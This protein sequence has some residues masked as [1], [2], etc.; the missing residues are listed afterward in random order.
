V[1]DGT[2]IHIYILGYKMMKLALIM[3]IL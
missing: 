1:V 3:K 2:F